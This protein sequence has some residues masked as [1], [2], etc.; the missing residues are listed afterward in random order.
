[1]A[2]TLY[3]DAEWAARNN[4]LEQLLFQLDDLVQPT[5]VSNERDFDWFNMKSA[6]LV[7]YMDNKNVH[8][9]VMRWREEVWRYIIKVHGPC[10]LVLTDPDRH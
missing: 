1:M 3:H 9:A 2:T 7:P 10:E 4:K 6:A 8:E 5:R